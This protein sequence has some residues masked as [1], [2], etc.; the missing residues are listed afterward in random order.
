MKSTLTALLLASTLAAGAQEQKAEPWYKTIKLSGYVMT[1]YQ[2]DGKEGSEANSFSLRMAR[3][4]LDGRIMGDFYWKAQLQV[5]G[6]TSSLGSSFGTM[7]EAIGGA[8]GETLQWASQTLQSIASVIPMIASLTTAKQA[9]AMA[10]ATASGSAMPFPLNIVAI[11]A[12]VA[13]VIAQFAKMPKFAAGGIAYGPTVGLFG[14]Y[15]G[16]AN[17]PEVVAPLD[18]LRSLITPA[19]GT[20]QRVDFKIEGRKLVGVLAKEQSVRN[21]R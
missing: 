4:A 10:G 18:R 7:G 16:A 9:E 15:A 11:A 2:Y 21:R 1:Q 12:G 17:N 20:A 6:N 8:A 13:A 19:E 5:N 3:L 14:E